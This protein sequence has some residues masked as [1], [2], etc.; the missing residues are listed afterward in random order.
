MATLLGRTVKGTVPLDAAV[1][2][3]VSVPV[4]NVSCRW[5]HA[6]R[7]AVRSLRHLE[8]F[9]CETPKLASGKVRLQLNV[10]A[11]VTKVAKVIA[12]D[13]RLT[14]GACSRRKLLGVI[15]GD[16]GLEGTPGVIGDD[17]TMI[18]C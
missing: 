4:P 1:E 2:S 11:W 5:R 8:V 14:V 9:A 3:T 6:L 7:S 13:V 16:S 12:P 10:P 18:D 15:S 17:S